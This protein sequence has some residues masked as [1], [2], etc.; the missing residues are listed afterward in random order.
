MTD[1]RCAY[2]AWAKPAG[3]DGDEYYGEQSYYDGDSQDSLFLGKLSS[4][5]LGVSVVAFV[6]LSILVL[7]YL[8]IGS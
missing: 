8:N 4:T 6:L 2:D 3:T 1:G 5:L 7:V